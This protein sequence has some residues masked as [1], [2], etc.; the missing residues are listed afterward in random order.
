MKI[1]RN[2]FQ[3]IARFAVSGLLFAFPFFQGISYRYLLPSFALI[4]CGAAIRFWCN[5]VLR[6]SREICQIGPYAIIRHPMYTG[7]FFITLGYLLLLNI[8]LRVVAGLMGCV[9]LVCIW[10]AIYEERR[11]SRIGMHDGYQAYKHNVPMLL[12]LPWVISRA[13]N[14]RRFSG[15]FNWERFVENGEVMRMALGLLALFAIWINMEIVMSTQ[16]G[17]TKLSLDYIG[18]AILLFIATLLFC[19]ILFRVRS[20]QKEPVSSSAHTE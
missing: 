9:I 8:E 6:K 3:R 15:H 1:R 2:W 20:T 14:E 18:P 11:F 4:L 7:T 12:P 19:Y 13:I 16:V 10:R 17:F 5:G